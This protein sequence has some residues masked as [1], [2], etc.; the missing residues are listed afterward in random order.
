MAEPLSHMPSSSPLEEENKRLKRAVEELSFLNDL[1][2]AIAVLYDSQEIMQ[3]IIRKSLRAVDA[4]QGVI[5]LVDSTR[6]EPN[7]TLVRTRASSTDRP[8]F[9]IHDALLGW[10]HLNKKPLLFTDPRDDDRFKGIHWN[11]TI[12]SML[13]VPLLIKSELKGVLTVFNKKNRSQF[14]EDDQ[15]LLSIIASQSAQVV[16]N[17]RLSEEE[18]A[19]SELREEVR[20]ASKIQADL[21]P[22]SVPTIPGYEIAARMIPAQMCGGDYYDFIPLEGDSVAICLG[23]VSGKGL[24]AS[25]LMANLQATLRGQ[26]TKSGD[27]CE[28]IRRSN[29]LLFRSTG[30]EKFATLF[31]GILHP[32]N[33]MLVYCNAGHNPPLLLRSDGRIEMLDTSGI[34]LGA[35]DDF[36]FSTGSTSFEPGDLLAIFS[37]G[38]TEA[39]NCHQEEFGEQR[40]RTEIQ[41]LRG[42]SA[43]NVLEAIFR[44]VRDHA[45]TYPQSD[46]ITVVIMRRT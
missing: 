18:K 25:L 1:A 41:H 9:Q 46:D 7:R 44:A 20:L 30:P 29:S 36:G 13:C 17:A 6:S 28:C 43:S 34:V 5:T 26:A 16:E 40:L 45:G 32:R 21:L 42:A 4:E 8:A 12:Q 2:R 37:D 19:L 27:V 24:P 39:W 11:D 35:L 15:R 23:D 14:S 38:V 10:M 33:N 31:Y 22:P 3:T